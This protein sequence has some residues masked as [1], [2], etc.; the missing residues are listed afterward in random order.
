MSGEL[1]CIC[2]LMMS[3]EKKLDRW[4]GGCIRGER[5]NMPYP[6]DLVLIRQ[7]SRSILSSVSTLL[8]KALHAIIQ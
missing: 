6:L 8:I 1:C 3:A 5:K 2:S 4:G 7:Y